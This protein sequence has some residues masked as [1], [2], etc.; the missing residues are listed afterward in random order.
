MSSSMGYSITAWLVS[1]CGIVV[2]VRGEGHPRVVVVVLG[3]PHLVGQSQ[4]YLGH[5]EEH[6]GPVSQVQQKP[7]DCALKKIKQGG[8]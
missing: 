8:L 6:G 2:V 5:P 7:K 1:Y 3:V 4:C